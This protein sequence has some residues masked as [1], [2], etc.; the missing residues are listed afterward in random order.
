MRSHWHLRLADSD[1][2][3]QLFQ[4]HLLLLL[5]FHLPAIVLFVAFHILEFLSLKVLLLLLVVLF[6]LPSFSVNVS[7]VTVWIS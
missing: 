2:L 4:S 3:D 7:Q 6:N 5:V 1:E